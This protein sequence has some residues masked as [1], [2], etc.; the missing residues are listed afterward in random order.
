VRAQILHLELHTGDLPAACD[1]YGRLLGWRPEAVT[2]MSWPYVS[3]DAG[4]SAGIVQCGA[5]APTWI[6]YVGVGD[7]DAATERAVSLGAT[8]LLAPRAGPHGRRS[9]V[10][11]AHAG[12]L[13]FWQT[14]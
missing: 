12:D 9:V 2:S 13:A 11:S 4:L 10:R 14:P 6:P 5:V 1:Y 8:P 3:V 7:V